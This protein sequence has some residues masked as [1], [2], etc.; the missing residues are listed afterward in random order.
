[1]GGKHHRRKRFKLDPKTQVGFRRYVK[2][3]E[4]AERLTVSGWKKGVSKGPYQE[5]A[6]P[7]RTWRE[8]TQL[9]PLALETEDK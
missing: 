2:N 3:R 1:M 4:R 8:P 6:V 9:V 5:G 7:W